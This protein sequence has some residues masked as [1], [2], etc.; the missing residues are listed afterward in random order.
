[1]KRLKE[2][3]GERCSS[4]CPALGVA[5]DHR[6]SPYV[7]RLH[8]DRTLL[9]CWQEIKSHYFFPRSPGLAFE[10]EDSHIYKPLK[11]KEDDENCNQVV[12]AFVQNERRMDV[13]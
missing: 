13:V 12:D 9:N 3:P 8:G 5:V 7:Q 2:A 1:M 11:L 4:P 6:D 10:I